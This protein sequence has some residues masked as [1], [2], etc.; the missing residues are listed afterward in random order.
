MLPVSEAL[1]LEL[2]EDAH[3]QC[4]V[5]NQGTNATTCLRHHQSAYTAHAFSVHCRTGTCALKAYELTNMTNS[6]LRIFWDV[7]WLQAWVYRPS[8]GSAMA[9]NN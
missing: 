1:K 6:E 2:F 8:E 5:Y 4:F 9:S 7:R 3:G